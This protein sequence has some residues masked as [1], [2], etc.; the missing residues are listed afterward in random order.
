MALTLESLY[1]PIQAELD[2]AHALVTELW[3]ETLELVHGPLISPPKTG[4]KLLRPAL[5]LL[6]GGAAGAEDVGAFVPL[7]AAIEM[8][9]VAALTHDDVVDKADLRRGAASL[10]ALW[11]DR[12]AVL[13]GDYLVSRSVGIMARYGSCGVMAT[14]FEAIQ[15]MTEGELA[16]FGRSTERFTQEDCLRIAEQKTASFFAATCSVPTF[17]AGAEFRQALYEYGMGLGVA[18]QLADDLLDMSQ[19]EATLGKP[20][21]SDVVGGKKTLPIL[22][23]REA[24]N[25]EDRNR[26]NRMTGRANGD[27]DRRWVAG[28]LDR[29]GARASTETIARGYSEKARAALGPLPSSAYKDSML[30]LAEFVLVR[31]S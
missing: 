5:C 14:T 3:G 27:Q 22:F 16:S 19:D 1:Q 29:S 7:A 9:H 26:L 21:C 12:M 18:F 25:V 17:A 13:S 15:C 2:E 4:G 24:L 11:D 6:S 8:L 31:G 30:E 28:M 10:N 23:M 20:S